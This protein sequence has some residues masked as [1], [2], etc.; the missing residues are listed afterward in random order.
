MMD[1]L[2]LV[3]RLVHF[4][5]NSS[6]NFIGSTTWNSCIFFPWGV[7]ANSFVTCSFCVYKHS[8]LELPLKSCSYSAHNLFSLWLTLLPSISDT[9]LSSLWANCILGLFSFEL[10]RILIATLTQMKIVRVVCKQEE[11][12]GK[13]RT[14]C[15]T[16]K[17][18]AHSNLSTD[19]LH[20]LCT[21]C[22]GYQRPF[23]AV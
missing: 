1:G 5:F 9:Y 12:F 21:T 17:E 4:V 7:A 10:R 22:S 13:R 19:S 18:V 20:N 11:F 6:W 14:G 8:A 2:P 16:L 15:K 23:C 3:R